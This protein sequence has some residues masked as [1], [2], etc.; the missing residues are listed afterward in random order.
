MRIL[1]CNWCDRDKPE[2]DFHRDRTRVNRFGRSNYCSACQTDRKREKRKDPKYAARE[3]ARS[4]KWRET[5]PKRAARS[6]RCATLRKKYGISADEYDQLLAEQGGVCKICGADNPQIK[7]PGKRTKNLYV[8]HDHKSGK[9]RGL[10]CQPCNTVLG[11][12][13]DDPI[14][15]R[16][17][18]KYLE[19]ADN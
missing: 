13:N 15:L 2:T 19:G 10:L 3:R 9:I 17:A 8:D 18:A 5:N 14:L 16:R 4:K 7:V 1:H 6:I 12:M 11:R